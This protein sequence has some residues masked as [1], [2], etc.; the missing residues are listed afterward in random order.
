MFEAAMPLR[1]L[2]ILEVTAEMLS[3]FQNTHVKDK[4]LE[5]EPAK[6]EGRRKHA[7]FSLFFNF[8]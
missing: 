8:F 2:L 4:K 3:S 1:S 5:L 7:S 6:V